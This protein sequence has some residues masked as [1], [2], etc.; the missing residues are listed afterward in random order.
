MILASPGPSEAIVA[1]VPIDSSVSQK[2]QTASDVSC[3]SMEIDAGGSVFSLAIAA[4]S[5]ATAQQKSMSPDDSLR[6]SKASNA[7]VVSS[8]KSAPI[9]SGTT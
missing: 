3:P 8:I 5:G 6:L 9:I 1:A 4:A 2:A 7:S